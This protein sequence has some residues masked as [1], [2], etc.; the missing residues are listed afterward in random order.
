MVEA[1]PPWKI[2]RLAVG[3]LGVGLRQIKANGLTGEGKLL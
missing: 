2:S 1:S 3:D